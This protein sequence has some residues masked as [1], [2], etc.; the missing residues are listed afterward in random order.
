EMVRWAPGK[1]AGARWLL[2]ADSGAGADSDLGI[3]G[4]VPVF[5]VDESVGVVVEAVGAQMVGIGGGGAQA[6]LAG[7]AHAKVAG[8]AA[9]VIGAVGKA[10]AVVVD[11]VTALCEGVLGGPGGVVIHGAGGV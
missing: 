8:L 7:L 6:L 3:V 2:L 11:A 5:T 1:R 10:V 4:A 9:A